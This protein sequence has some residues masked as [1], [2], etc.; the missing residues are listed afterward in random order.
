[1]SRIRH[2]D[3]LEFIPGRKSNIHHSIFDG[4][5]VGI[6]MDGRRKREDRNL[7]VAAEVGVDHCLSDFETFDKG[8]E[9]SIPEY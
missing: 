1:M 9:K 2:L 6:A 3:I 4:C 5:N 7:N 8:F